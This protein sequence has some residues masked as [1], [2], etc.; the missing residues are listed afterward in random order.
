MI[1]LFYALTPL[2][3]KH[4]YKWLLAI[5]IEII[6][7]IGNLFLTFD[8]RLFAYFPFYVI[9]LLLKDEYK[10]YNDISALIRILIIIC[11]I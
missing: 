10:K 7:I 1:L 8:E 5:V 6:L 4:K 3:L 2:L 9:G 11:G